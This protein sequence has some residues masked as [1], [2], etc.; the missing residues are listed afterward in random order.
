[1]ENGPRL[2]LEAKR[3]EQLLEEPKQKVKVSFP[4]WQVAWGW[5]GESKYFERFSSEAETVEE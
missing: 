1:M 2:S 4:S 3:T 5:R